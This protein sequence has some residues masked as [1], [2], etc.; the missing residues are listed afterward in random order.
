MKPND[1][2]ELSEIFIGEDGLLSIYH[3]NHECEITGALSTVFGD[4]LVGKQ[5]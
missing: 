3:N 5:K 4:S 2:N 1:K